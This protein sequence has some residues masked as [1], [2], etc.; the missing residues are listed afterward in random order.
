M[1]T[2]IQIINQDKHG[3]TGY[4]DYKFKNNTI[5][6]TLVRGM[7]K[8]QRINIPL[9]DITNIIVE[10][11]YGTNRISFDYNSQKYIFLNSG[12]GENEYLI[13]HLTEAVKI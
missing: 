11:F 5:S 4:V 10:N 1:F 12:Y 9:S 3:F 8:L 6:M 13:K 2:Y 7:R